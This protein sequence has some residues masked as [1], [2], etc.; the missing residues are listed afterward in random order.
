MRLRAPDGEGLRNALWGLVR[1]NYFQNYETPN[2]I[3]EK[4]TKGAPGVA[5]KETCTDVR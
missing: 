5:L 4:T 2:T 1:T 3:S